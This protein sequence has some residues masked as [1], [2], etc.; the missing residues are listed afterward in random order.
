MDTQSIIAAI[1]AEISNLEK[2]RTVLTGVVRASAVAATALKPR[3]KP[4]LS[5]AARKRIGDAQRKR[6][7]AA[8]QAVKTTP[9]NVAKKAAA[10]AK[11]RGMSAES[12]KRIAAAQRKRWAAVKKAAK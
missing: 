8:K 3:K 12:K 1:D 4:R 9:A 5:K 11:K 7:A 2:A 6:W 10:P